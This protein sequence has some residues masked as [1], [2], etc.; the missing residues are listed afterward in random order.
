[1]LTIQDV[2]N[3]KK[4]DRKRPDEGELRRL[5]FKHAFIYGRLSSPGQVRDSRESVRE[6]ARLVELAIKDGF[7]TNLSSD[8]VE[9]KLISL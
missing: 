9:I 1:M 3:S 5:P 6:I 8:D 4:R 2:I 7:K